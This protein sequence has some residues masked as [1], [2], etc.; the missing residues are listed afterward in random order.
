MF[1]QGEYPDNYFKRFGKAISPF[2]IRFVVLIV[3]LLVASLI[4]FPT[5]VVPEW[6]IRLVDRTGKPVAGAKVRQSWLHYSLESRGHAED[7]LTDENGYVVFP[8]RKIWANAVYR[9]VST[10][11]AALSLLFHGSMGIDAWVLVI[12][13][14]GNLRHYVPGKPLPEVIVVQ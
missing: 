14:Y 7:R 1:E 13:P 3:F 8:E 5:T 4:P 12:S 2:P 11:M 6:K 9:V 10:L